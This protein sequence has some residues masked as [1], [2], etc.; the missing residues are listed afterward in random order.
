VSSC[1]L[2]WL[3]RLDGEELILLLL[4]LSF[5]VGAHA[6]QL[7]CTSTIHLYDSDERCADSAVPCVRIDLGPYPTIASVSLGTTR[8]F[9]LRQVQSKDPAIRSTEVDARTYDVPLKNNTVRLPFL[10]LRHSCCALVALV[11]S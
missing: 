2:G 7:T 10:L 5:S 11:R 4:R 3:V 9:R 8:K 6:D 1:L